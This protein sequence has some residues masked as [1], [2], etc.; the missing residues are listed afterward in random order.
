MTKKLLRTALAAAAFTLLAAASDAAAQSAS[1]T[2]QVSAAVV[3]TCTISATA[4][5]FGAYDTVGANATAPADQTGTV[6]LRCTRGTNYSVA[7]GQGDNFS[8]GR[9]M[10]LG[11]SGEYLSYQL[12]SDAGRTSVWDGAAPV[13]GTA[14]NR[15]AFN[16]TVFGRVPAAQ[17]VIEGAYLDTISATVNF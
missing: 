16:L 17:D 15:S 8:G 11:A 1:A 5:D 9:R 6:T 10:R 14:A 12:Y 7:L 4:I 13:S 3:K 2:F